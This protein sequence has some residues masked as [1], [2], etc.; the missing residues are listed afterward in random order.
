MDGDHREPAASPSNLPLVSVVTPSLDQGRYIEDA[1]ASVLAQDYP[2]IEHVVVDGGSHDD[3]LATVGRLAERHPDRLRWVSER[4]SGQAAAINKG[5]RMTQ[6]E[7]LAWLNADDAY[8]PAAISTAVRTL[9]QHAPASL[10][11]GDAVLTDAEG[12]LLGPCTYVRP[13]DRAAMLAWGDLVAQPAA[14]FRRSAYEAVSGLDESL[15]W[16]LDYDLWLKISALGP[17]VY[18]PVALARYRW[19][20]DNKTARGGL[21]RLDEIERVARRH[22]GEGLPASFRGERIKGLVRALVAGPTAVSAPKGRLATAGQL[23]RE[24]LAAASRRIRG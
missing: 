6:G 23:V 9:S 2:R 3:T 17:A 19:T 13:F 7:I 10:V 1:I 18:V 8:E 20:G 11:Y 12:R 22:G 21:A 24:T 4:D 16:A 5:F 15:H 14:F